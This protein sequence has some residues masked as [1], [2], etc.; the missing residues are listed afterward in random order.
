MPNDVSIM[1]VRQIRRGGLREQFNI[2]IHL[3]KK[4]KTFLRKR[5]N[6]A[7]EYIS[8]YLFH[9]EGKGYYSTG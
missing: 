5:L 9:R 6:V 1:I 7:P 2:K 3:N 8:E 4:T